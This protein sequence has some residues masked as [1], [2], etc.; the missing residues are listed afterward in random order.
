MADPAPSTAKRRRASPQ[1]R[2]RLRL[3]GAVVA[4][5]LV[6]VFAVVNLDEV[7]V[8]WIVGTWSTPLI[9]VIAVAALLGAAADR[10][11]QVRSKRRAKR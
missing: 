7:E 1:R 4:A 9:V 8:N 6:T 2:E 3:L 5:V 10:L 11:L